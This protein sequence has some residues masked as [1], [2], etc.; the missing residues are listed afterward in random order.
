MS[1]N[2]SCTIIVVF[3]TLMVNQFY[4]ETFFPEDPCESCFI[5]GDIFVVNFAGV[6]ITTNDPKTWSTFNVINFIAV[7]V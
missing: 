6:S 7:T 1:V 4:L 2:I 3:K 5:S